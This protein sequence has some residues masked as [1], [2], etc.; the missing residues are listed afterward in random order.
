MDIFIGAL[1]GW[2]VTRAIS[3]LTSGAKE[4]SVAQRINVAIVGP[5][6]PKSQ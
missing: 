4:G 5:W 2:A 1:I 3:A 6:R